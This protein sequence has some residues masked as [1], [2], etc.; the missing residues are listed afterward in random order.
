MPSLL[1]GECGLYN[2]ASRK[3][4]QR[5]VW[6]IRAEDMVGA[7]T[8][9]AMAALQC[10]ASHSSPAGK[11]IPRDRRPA[12]RPGLFPSGAG[13]R[14]KQPVMDWIWIPSPADSLLGG[15]NYRHWSGL[16]LSTNYHG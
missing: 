11:N 7:G 8:A 9:P 6:R 2:G 10:D 13:A 5:Q 14:R 4:G 15:E 16:L 1:P 12:R 3:P